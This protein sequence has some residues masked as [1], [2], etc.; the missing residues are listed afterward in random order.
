VKL[1]KGSYC[2]DCNR[3]SSQESLARNPM[4]SKCGVNPHATKTPWCLSC[5][6]EYQKILRKKNPGRWYRAITPLQK[7]KRD[8]RIVIYGLIKLGIMERK[9]CGICGNVKSEGHHHKGYEGANA[10]DVIWLCK[11]HHFEADQKLN[12]TGGRPRTT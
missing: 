5:R 1:G 6:N 3:K 7:R 11:R 9:P 4:C 8:S 2:G 12:L 10:I